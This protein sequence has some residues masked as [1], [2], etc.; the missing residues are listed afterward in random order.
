MVTKMGLVHL[1]LVAG[2]I[3]KVLSAPDSP[4][5]IYIIMDDMG[6]SDMSSRGG[7]YSTPNLDELYANSINLQYHYIGLLCSPSRSQILTGRYAWNFGLSNMMPF[8]YTQIAAVPT[9]FPTIA[10]ILREY[11]GYDTYAVGKWHTGYS[12][13]AHTPLYRGFD[14]YYGFLVNGIWYTNKTVEL[15]FIEGAYIDWWANENVDHYTQY[16]YSTFVSR[17]KAVAIINKHAS[18]DGTNENP[19]YIYLA[20]QAP[21]ETL[22]NIESDGSDTCDTITD[23][24][25]KQ[26]CENIVA[27]DN[28]VG[29]I[30]STL[31][32]NDLYD[33]TLIVFTTDN[34]GMFSSGG[35]N[36]PLRYAVYI[37]IYI[38]DNN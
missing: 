16:V 12:S 11:G 8:G 7:E 31:E 35:C 6:F 18:S 17:N 33:N 28:S 22:Q 25:R 26:Y 10:N 9:G 4:N 20:F 3:A 30:V 34:G 2:L 37:Y 13:D 24:T 29:S 14:E 23:S 27:V 21:H 32:E 38:F 15:P 5:I 19:F 36:Y 1:A